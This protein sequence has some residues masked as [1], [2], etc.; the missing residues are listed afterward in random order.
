[1]KKIIMLVLVLAMFLLSSMACFAAV[2]TE[3]DDSEIEPMYVATQSQSATFT[4]SSK[5]LATMDVSL[6]PLSSTTIDKVNVT[7]SIKNSSGKSVFNK[8]YDMTWS[9]ISMRF[10]LSKEY[11]L[12]QNGTYEFQ[13][14]YKCYKNNSLI[15]TIKSS[16]I[17][18]S[19]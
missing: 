12:S 19:Y 9:S 5:G 10:K 2:P 1:M 17:L 8:S 13:A 7:L 16:S 18:K 6:A 3:R 4:I 15:E 14:T 11:Q